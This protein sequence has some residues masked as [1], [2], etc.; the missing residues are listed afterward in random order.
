MKIFGLS[1]LLPPK[2]K[3]IKTVFEFYQRNS[4]ECLKQMNIKAYMKLSVY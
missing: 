3:K 2:P 4:N 1:A